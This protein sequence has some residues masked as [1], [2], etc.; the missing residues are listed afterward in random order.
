MFS[1]VPPICDSESDMKAYE[2]YRNGQEY[3]ENGQLELGLPLMK[4]AMKLSSME[5][6]QYL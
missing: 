3:A 6:Q 1:R 4:K 2:M 5:L